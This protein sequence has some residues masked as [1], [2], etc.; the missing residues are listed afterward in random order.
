MAEVLSSPEGDEEV[1]EPESNHI[2]AFL[3][4]ARIASGDES[5]EWMG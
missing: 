3:G 4:E 2:L 1:D 5:G